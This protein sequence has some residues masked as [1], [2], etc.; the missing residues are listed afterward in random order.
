ME[1]FKERILEN[2]NLAEGDKQILWKEYEKQLQDLQKQLLLAQAEEQNQLKLRID[3]RK[4]K[5]DKLLAEKEK[6]G[7]EKRGN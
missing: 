2:S 3:A 6:Y 1:D 4:A 5:R 7:E